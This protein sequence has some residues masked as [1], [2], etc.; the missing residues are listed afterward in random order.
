MYDFLF[1]LSEGCGLLGDRGDGYTAATQSSWSSDAD[2]SRTM[3]RRVV[4]KTR[5]SVQV[6]PPFIPAG[7][8]ST[9]PETRGCTHDSVAYVSLSP[10][11]PSLRPQ[12]RC[13]TMYNIHLR[14]G[15]AFRRSSDV[16]ACI[17]VQGAV[18]PSLKRVTAECALLHGCTRIVTR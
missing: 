17:P 14:S 16:S 4:S 1:V 7:Q 11:S 9:P 10:C 15:Y 8:P 2:W 5:S 12:Q 13:T 18:L 6:G 3:S